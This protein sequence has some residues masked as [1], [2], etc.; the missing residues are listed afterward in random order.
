ML[1]HILFKHKK[2]KFKGFWQLFDFVYNIVLFF[3]INV[4]L[5]FCIFDINKN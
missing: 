1:R 3:V 2:V 4:L 5:L